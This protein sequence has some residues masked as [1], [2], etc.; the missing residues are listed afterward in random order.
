MGVVLPTI[1]TANTKPK[2][3]NL[4]LCV[5]SHKSGVPVLTCLMSIKG[6]PPEH[7]EVLLIHPGN[8]QAMYKHI[9]GH[10]A[11]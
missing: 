5:M 7:H 8:L 11:V 4:Q 1:S 10:S 6:L 9:N 3:C 2:P